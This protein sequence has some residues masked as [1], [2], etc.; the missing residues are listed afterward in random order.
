MRTKAQK[1]EPGG[2]GC[3]L[4]RGTGRPD[5]A[6]CGCACHGALQTSPGKGRTS[7][8]LRAGLE[9]RHI[10]NPFHR[11]VAGPG[12]AQPGAAHDDCQAES[13]FL[14]PECAQQYS[15]GTCGDPNPAGGSPALTK[16][17]HCKLQAKGL[18]GQHGH[19]SS[20][21]R[22]PRGH[23]CCCRSVLATNSPRT[24]VTP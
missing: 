19:V 10:R 17:S 23:S 11:G 20:A 6:L 13:R 9:L 22:L 14:C 15:E 4:G 16:P 12:R 24:L 7:Q 3:Q 21:L 18:P 5:S 8:Q 2:W 1:E